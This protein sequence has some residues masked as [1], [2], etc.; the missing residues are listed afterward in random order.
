MRVLQSDVCCNKIEN[1]KLVWCATFNRAWFLYCQRLVAISPIWRNDKVRFVALCYDVIRSD[2][3]VPI[4]EAIVLIGE[5]SLAAKNFST[6]N[7]IVK[8]DIKT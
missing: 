6:I 8:I 4:V 7:P 3:M 1:Y 5:K 2:A